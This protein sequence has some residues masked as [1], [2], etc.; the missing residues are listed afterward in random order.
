[1]FFISGVVWATRTLAGW[2]LHRS[3]KE[4]TRTDK[5][6]NISPPA[7][8]PNWALEVTVP[9]LGILA[10]VLV[11]LA[12]RVAVADVSPPT[13]LPVVVALFRVS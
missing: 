10:A 3:Y 11:A 12:G 6:R 7:M 5:P 2:I 1:M 9:L 8:V 13:V 4:S